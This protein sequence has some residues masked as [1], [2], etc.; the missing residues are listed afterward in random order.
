MKF[1]NHLYVTIYHLCNK[2]KTISFRLNILSIGDVLIRHL[3][4]LS[5]NKIGQQ[6]DFL[7]FFVICITQLITKIIIIIWREGHIK[8]LL[9]LIYI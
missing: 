8:K 6:N 3:L 1:I 2:K 9:L 7:F 5:E 4:A